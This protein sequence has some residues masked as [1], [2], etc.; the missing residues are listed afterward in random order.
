MG[1]K[2]Q[3]AHWR[4]LAAP[5]PVPAFRCAS[6]WRC[7]REE[8]ESGKGNRAFHA[9]SG[10]PA[11]RVPA[12]PGTRIAL[13]GPAIIPETE[14]LCENNLAAECLLSQDP[15]S[16]HLTFLSIQLL[17]FVGVTERGPVGRAGFLPAARG[18]VGPV[19]SSPGVAM[20]AVLTLI[21]RKVNY[22]SIIRPSSP[23]RRLGC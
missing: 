21:L 12:I 22:L 11:L 13:P 4:A 5:A 2:L 18:T 17:P 10:V 20:W 8:A 6:A 14:R 23:D 7:L 19:C 16:F 15:G 3:A 9:A 1:V